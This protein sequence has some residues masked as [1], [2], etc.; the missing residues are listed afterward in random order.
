MR[1]SRE[2]TQFYPAPG[3]SPA[4]GNI[5]R[6]DVELVTQVSLD[7]WPRFAQQA[8]AWRGPASVAVYV[9]CPPDHPLAPQ[10]LAHLQQ[11]AQQ[12][13]TALS[14]AVAGEHAAAASVSAA[15]AAAAAAAGVAGQ[16]SGN[17]PAPSPPLLAVSILHSRHVAA[18][19]AGVLGTRPGPPP[20]EA[21]EAPGSSSGTTTTTTSTTSATTSTSA[22]TS[23]RAGTDV[24][25]HLYPINALR[26]AALAAAR[27]SHVFLVDGDFIP[28]AGLRADLLLGPA[29]AGSSS[30][31]GS[32]SSDVG[33]SPL[34]GSD[35]HGRPVMWVV[36]AFELAAPAAA[37]PAAAGAGGGSLP[38][39]VAVAEVPDEQ[40]A[41]VPRTLGQLLSYEHGAPQQGGSKVVG[42]APRRPVLRPFHCGRYP[43]P[44][45]SVDYAGWLADAAAAARQ[46]GQQQ[47]Q[48]Q[49]EA[50]VAG[51]GELLWR[52]VPYHEYFEPYGIVRRDQVPFY[53][54]RFRGYGLNK[55][56]HAYHMA[57]A[58]FQFRLLR[59][60]FCV[61]VPHARSASYRAAFGTAADPQQRLRVERLYADFKA[62]MR[63]AHGYEYGGAATS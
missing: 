25:E 32:S 30:G 45:P 1:Q 60:H 33:A 44:V 50:G 13:D 27:S 12:L 2:A 31:S 54:E 6:R 61:T 17:P 51:S 5:G 29:A 52:E 40:T 55:V 20:A 37:A 28:S 16:R 58:G 47:Q 26:N 19:G 8:L 7:R 36:P 23:T 43:Q 34:D 62:A 41:A 21:P 38:A 11:L 53:D 35:A 39:A 63:E 49:Q 22:N 10:Y 15:A 4:S 42:G 14:E 56:Q 18:E 57:A 24:Y 48:Q 46:E 9:P 3:A 59:R